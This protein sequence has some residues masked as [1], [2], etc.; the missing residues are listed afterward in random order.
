MALSTHTLTWE[1]ALKEAYVPAIKK[2]LD[3][4]LAARFLSREEIYQKY[5]ALD[6]PGRE[7]RDAVTAIRKEH[8]LP[9]S[10]PR[11]KAGT[12]DGII[13]SSESFWR[14]QKDDAFEAVMTIKTTMLV[15]TPQCCA[16]ITDISE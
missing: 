16:R 9:V 5:Q 6:D 1:P 14:N 4:N 12:I 2:M 7:L 3:Q 13:R 10:E 15:D 8:G 11:S